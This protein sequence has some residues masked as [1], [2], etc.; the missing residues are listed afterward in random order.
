MKIKYL[1]N[2]C[3]DRLHSHSEE[4]LYMTNPNY[5]TYFMSL[6][7]EI[8]EMEGKIS[9]TDNKKFLYC[10][11]FIGMYYIAYLG[12]LTHVILQSGKFH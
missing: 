11:S 12:L 1:K 6:D 5:K 4:L 8:M 9:L 7:Q 3:I 2:Y 10:I